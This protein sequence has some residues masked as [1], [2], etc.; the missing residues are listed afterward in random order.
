MSSHARNNRT[1]PV[2]FD[3]IAKVSSLVIDLNSVV[4]ELFESSAVENTIPGRTRVVDHKFVLSG[5]SFGT[6]WLKRRA[7]SAY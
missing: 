3:I 1:F 7:Q 6:L 5:S 4:Q 2:D